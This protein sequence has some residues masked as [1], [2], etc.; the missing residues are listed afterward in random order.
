MKRSR[1]AAAHLVLGAFLIT[2]HSAHPQTVQ[3]PAA[4]SPTVERDHVGECTG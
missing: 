2:A 3:Q 1:I 4:S